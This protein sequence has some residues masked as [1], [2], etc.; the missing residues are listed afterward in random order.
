MTSKSESFNFMVLKY[1]D[2]GNFNW[3][4]LVLDLAGQD[5]YFPKHP[6]DKEDDQN[7]LIV[8]TSSHERVAH[9]RVQI[10]NLQISLVNFTLAQFHVNSFKGQLISKCP[11]GFFKFPK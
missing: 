3:G 7:S 4:K 11:F 9:I 6:G 10:S 2:F 1:I 5:V 8:T